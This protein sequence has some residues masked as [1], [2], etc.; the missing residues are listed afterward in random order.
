MP[1]FIKCFRD[2]KESTTHI[3]EWVSIKTFITDSNCETQESP[4]I[5]PDWQGVNNLF[6]KKKLNNVLKTSLLKT[7]LNIG[8]R[9]IGR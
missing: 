9:L 6:C 4:G 2:I 3:V 7:L 8:R 5:K 1:N